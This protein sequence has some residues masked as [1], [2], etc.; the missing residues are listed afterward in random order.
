MICVGFC[1][2][3]MFSALA[4]VLIAV[5]PQSEG[6]VNWRP[7]AKNPPPDPPPAPPEPPRR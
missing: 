5:R 1:C 7:P 3:L 4:W 6:E 2:G